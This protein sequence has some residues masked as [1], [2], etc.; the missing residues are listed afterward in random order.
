M[1]YVNFEFPEENAKDALMH[2]LYL[3]EPGTLII[4]DLEDHGHC[5]EY[6]G[7]A[8]TTARADQWNTYCVMFKQECVALS[9]DG[10]RGIM[11]GPKAEQWSFTSEYFVL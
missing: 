10:K 4:Y 3:T 11:C 8:K 6:K 9:V 1:N 2:L 5:Y 7:K